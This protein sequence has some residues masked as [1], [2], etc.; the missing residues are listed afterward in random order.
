[1][2]QT[3]FM[4]NRK[5]WAADQRIMRRVVRSGEMATLLGAGGAIWR[6]KGRTLVL[7]PD[8]ISLKFMASRDSFEIN[9][10]KIQAAHWF[11]TRIGTHLR[12]YFWRKT[13]LRMSGQ[14]SWKM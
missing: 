14:N 2:P 6:T 5:R 3:G 1:M 9:A 7:S 12:R 8:C 4:R 10:K 13:F 11:S